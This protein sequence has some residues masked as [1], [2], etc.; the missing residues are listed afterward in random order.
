MASNSFDSEAAD[1][2]EGE[3]LADTQVLPGGR[4]Q[5]TVSSANAASSG[6]GGP[7]HSVA[8]RVMD[9]LQAHNYQRTM[10]CQ[11]R[12]RE[13][14]LLNTMT[15]LAELAAKQVA[16]KE[17]AGALQDETPPV[18]EEVRSLLKRDGARTRQKQRRATKRHYKALAEDDDSQHQRHGGRD[19]R[20]RS[21]HG[22]RSKS[23]S[24]TGHRQHS[25]GQSSTRR[26]TSQQHSGQGSQSWR[27]ASQHSGKGS[28]P[29]RGASQQSDK[30]TYPWRVASQERGKGSQWRAGTSEHS[31]KGSSWQ[32]GRGYQRGGGRG[33]GYQRGGGTT[34]YGSIR[35]TSVCWGVE[36]TRA[37]R[38]LRIPAVRGPPA[39][40]PAKAKGSV[41]TAL[42][43][44]PAP[45]ATEPQGHS[46][47]GK[48]PSRGM[49]TRNVSVSPSYTKSPS[50]SSTYRD[51]SP[52][53]SRSPT[54]SP[55]EVP[56][57]ASLA[58]PPC[59]APTH[60]Q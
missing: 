51:P 21:R 27:G 47:G 12:I 33:Q 11:E 24:R 54:V 18:P 23:R 15:R 5:M 1:S 38:D 41:A 34:S 9:I 32:R 4:R 57:D 42:G 48:S 36:D 13:T 28:P 58:G 14:S 50:R 40:G 22:R 10:E 52:S 25:P 29:R 3:V 49:R 53:R 31:G 19:S 55:A 46:G 60:G 17:P 20:S 8:S 37:R 2:D 7:G 59:D 35:L 56:C 44:A 26:C 16:D 39:S 45:T 43:S 6:S 30:S